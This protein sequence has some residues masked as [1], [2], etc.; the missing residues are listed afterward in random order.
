M[1]YGLTI[2]SNVESEQGAMQLALGTFFPVLLLSGV[3][4]PNQGN[5]HA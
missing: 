5:A 2:A 4:W 3:I 1:M